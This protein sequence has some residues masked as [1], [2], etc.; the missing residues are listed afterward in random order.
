MAPEQLEGK[1]A[2]A[3][4]DIFAFGAV[5]YE[6]ATGRKAFAGTSQASLISR[7][8][9]GRSAADL[10]GPADDAAGARP[11][12]EDVPRQGSR[13]PLADRARDVG[14]ELSGSRRDRPPATA[15]PR[16]PS[17][18]RR[19]TCA[20][21]S[22]GPSRPL[23]VVAAPRCRSCSRRPPARPEE[24]LRFT[25]MPP[26]GQGFLGAPELSPDAR[27]ILLVV[28][29]AGRAGTAIGDPL[30]RQPRDPSPCRAPRTR[31]APSGRPTA[32]RSRSSRKAAQ[33][34]RRGR[35]PRS[36]DLR[37]RERLLRRVGPRRH[38]PLHEGVRHSDRRR[39]R[40]REARPAPSPTIDPARGE[41]AHFHPAFLPDGRHF[42]FVARNIDPEKTSAM[43][44][45]LDSKD[46]RP[47]FHA[48]SARRLRRSGLPALRA[49]QR[50]SSPGVRS[51]ELEAR[52]ATR[53]GARAGPVRDR[54][55]P[56]VG[57]RRPGTAWPICRGP[58][59][60]GSSGW[61]ARG[62]SSERSARSAA[63]R[64]F[65]SRRTAERVAVTLRDPGRTV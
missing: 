14:S 20:R 22:P 38:D 5:L 57:T 27:R 18:P 21:R 10:A 54:R 34:H 17:S 33:A 29:D 56:P 35:R 43:L 7:D 2:D 48:D 12:R 1:E 60:G 13:G 58:G 39:P 61:T 19:R 4:T 46:V 26:P 64:T 9:E 42:V 45:S 25:I 49:G 59:G 51:A 50:R 47:L 31:A 23:A 28:Q 16:P 55:Q 24:S 3:R 37:Q 40:R 65:A 8:H 32:A 52:R 44:A 30:A 41:V 11:H 63:T 15:T 53:A 36:D 6:M 62:A